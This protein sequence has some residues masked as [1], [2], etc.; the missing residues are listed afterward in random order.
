MKK[1]F[2]LALM[3]LL[4]LMFSSTCKGNFSA[5]PLELSITMDNEFMH[6]NISKKIKIT[7][8]ND[9]SLNVTWYLACHPTE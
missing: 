1:T 2:A 9:Y 7:N 8:N 3:I 4:P 5:Q 6:G